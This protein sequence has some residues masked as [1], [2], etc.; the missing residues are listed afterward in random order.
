[1]K[2]KISLL[3]HGPLISKKKSIKHNC[4]ED[5]KLLFRYSN[6]FNY[7]I[8]STWKSEDT[9]NLEKY[10]KKK[11]I[12]IIKN[13]IPSKKSFSNSSLNP[14]KNKYLQAYSVLRGLQFLKQLNIGENK[15][16][17]YVIKIRT[18]QKFNKLPIL[19]KYI[20]NKNISNNSIYIRCFKRS[21]PFFLTDTILIGKLEM[22][23]KIFNHHY[24]QLQMYNNVHYDLFASLL[25]VV[26]PKKFMSSN[27]IFPSSF[28]LMFQENRLT[29]KQLKLIKKLWLKNIYL[30]PKKIIYPF[31]WRGKQR[32]YST[33]ELYLED[34]HPEHF[35]RY[36]NYLIKKNTQTLQYFNL[37]KYSF[38]L[39]FLNS[40]KRSIFMVGLF[41]QF[42]KNFSIECYYI[43]FQMR[44]LAKNLINN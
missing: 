30:I 27:L 5:L 36:F 6:L 21:L 23:L 42:F 15:K 14:S 43:Y 20:Q 19:K 17:N 9:I 2:K 29:P 11:N 44:S 34:L 4:L 33:N 38:R 10:I 1:M 7:I 41:L 40:S 24:A 3:V 18:D 13:K 31:F 12:F 8:I 39:Y 25:K 37:F 26:T 22:L 32:S 28:S 16:K 35:E